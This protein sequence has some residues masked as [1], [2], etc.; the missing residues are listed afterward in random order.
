MPADR[1]LAICGS[2]KPAPGA[3]GRS[4]A[5]EL[6]RAV[7]AGATEAG[8]DCDWLDL[9]DLDLPLFDGRGPDRYPDPDLARAAQLVADARVVLLSV[10][11]YWGG[12]AG[13]VKNFLDLLGGPAY[14]APPEQEPPL[15]GKVFA[16]LV[17]GADPVSGPAALGAMR[18]TLGTMG[19]WVAPRAEVVGDL[20][21]TRNV[22]ALLARLKDF[23]HHVASL[24]APDAG[25]AVPDA[26]SAVP[27]AGS[28]VPDAGSTVPA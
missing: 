24:S 16:L 2:R 22:A 20:R 9:R 28:T 27:D 18:L 14:D 7:C 17:V 11:A 10:P 26:G 4:A 15:A 5:R 19:A 13:V 12:P 1:V 25:S 21:T 3:P 23:G 6:L 8:A